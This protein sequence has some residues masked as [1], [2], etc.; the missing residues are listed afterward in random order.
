MLIENQVIEYVVQYLQ[1]GGF[2]IETVSRTS[3]RGY[4]IK[5]KKGNKFLYVEA[6]GQTS[7]KGYNRYGKEFTKNQKKDHV[8]KQYM[9][10]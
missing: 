10:L 2:E 3:E 1:E 9:K 7:S 6:K 8:V 5:A 4:D